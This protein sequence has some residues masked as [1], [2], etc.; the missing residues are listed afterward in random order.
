[1]KRALEM[2]ELPPEKLAEILMRWWEEE[3]RFWAEQAAII[4]RAVERARQRPGWVEPEPGISI[5][6]TLYFGEEKADE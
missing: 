2:L 5:T 1:M 4:N 3:E 6:E